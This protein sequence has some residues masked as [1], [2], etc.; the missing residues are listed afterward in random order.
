MRALVAV[1]A[2]LGG[3]RAPVVA[4]HCAA[5]P[6][7]S[8]AVEVDATAIEPPTPSTP[9]AASSEGAAARSRILGHSTWLP[10]APGLAIAS[11]D[12]LASLDRG[13]RHDEPNHWMETGRE[14]LLVGGS[15]LWLVT[16]E[17]EGDEAVTLAVRRD[18]RW[19]EIVSMLGIN[20][21]GLG[22]SMEVVERWFDESRSTAL[23]VLRCNRRMRGSQPPTGN[24]IYPNGSMS[25]LVLGLHEDRGFLALPETEGYNDL[26]LEVSPKGGSPTLVA[27][28]ARPR[29]GREARVYD[30]EHERFSPPG[31]GAL[32]CH[33]EV[34][35]E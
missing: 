25:W 24:F 8:S 17:Y 20:N 19:F 27:R 14:Q 11:L 7:S 29:G 31:P 28:C 9:S 23:L 18:D 13:L 33:V 5:P 4:E 16:L 15:E 21:G 22:A 35:D 26:H 3:C 34:L 12:G 2:L 6:P 32:R 30:P 1:L 10:A